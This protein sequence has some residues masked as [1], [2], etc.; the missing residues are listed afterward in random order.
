LYIEFVLFFK[1]KKVLFCFVR[2]LKRKFVTFLTLSFCLKNK[3]LKI[4]TTVL[5][6]QNYSI[7]NKCFADIQSQ[8]G[9]FV[10][11]E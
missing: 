4:A 6:M 10:I 9:V 3:I 2:N 11:V 7:T 1:K 5:S 8:W